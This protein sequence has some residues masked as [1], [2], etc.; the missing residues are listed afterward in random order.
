MIPLLLCIIIWSLISITIFIFIYNYIT[1]IYFYN[2][3]AQL[4]IDSKSSL[5]PFRYFQDIKGNILPFVAVT[6]FFRSKEMVKKYYEYVNN[7]INVFGITAYKTFPKEFNI[8]D[9]SEGV[10][11]NNQEFN[12]VKNIKNWLC[13]FNEPKEYGFTNENNLIDMSESDF[14]DINLNLVNN[15]KYDFIYICLKDNDNCPR[16]GWNAINRNFDLA[17]KCFP[18]MVNEFGMNGLVVGRVNCNLEEKFNGKIEVVDALDY[19]IL[20]EKMA[21]SK[22]L[23][24]PNIYDASPRV[25]SECL[26]KNVP[27]LMNKNIVCGSKYI[28]Y[29][30]GE[31][32]TNESDIKFALINLMSKLDKISPQKWWRE[33][34]GKD[35]SEKK[36]CVFLKNAFPNTLDNIENVQFV[37]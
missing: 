36:L 27:V 21:Q 28:N 34:Y 7:N 30:T 16:N 18:I 37:L 25:V 13:C 19:H 5:F 23:F 17:L 35:I 9:K 2:Y 8:I 10:Y 1:N 20:Q 33:N 12:Y 24:V 3:K 15:K 6:G 29:E 4:K 22:F 26:I 11:I 14:Y 32:F 31:L